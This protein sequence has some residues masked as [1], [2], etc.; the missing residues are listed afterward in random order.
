MP[1]EEILAF[2]IDALNIF[3]PGDGGSIIGGG[4]TFI[5]VRLIWNS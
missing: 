1:V 3:I 5:P 2:I 4:I